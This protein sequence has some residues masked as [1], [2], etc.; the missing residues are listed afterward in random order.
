[1]WQEV[2]R[3]PG[4]HVL[5]ALDLFRKADRVT[6]ECV[7]A[8]LL[9]CDTPESYDRLEQAALRCGKGSYE[10]LRLDAVGRN[11]DAIVRG[12]RFAGVN[13]ETVT[14]PIG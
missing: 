9:G 11:V 6:R 10:D 14:K 1:M 4:D 7:E 3:T 12:L 2:K 5:E 8:L 13:L